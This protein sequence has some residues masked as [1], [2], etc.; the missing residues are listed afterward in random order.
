M[1]NNIEN[2]NTVVLEKS[3]NSHVLKGK[4]KVLK[5]MEKM[6]TIV[7]ECDGGVIVEH[8]EHA[9]VRTENNTKYVIKITQQEFNPVTKALMN[10]CD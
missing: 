9:T 3:T 7:L 2:T 1:E 5:N 10:A 4:V 6:N 8:G